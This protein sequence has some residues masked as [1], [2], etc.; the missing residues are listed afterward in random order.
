MQ[1]NHIHKGFCSFCKFLLSL[2]Y[3][4]YCQLPNGGVGITPFFLL[5]F[6]YGPFVTK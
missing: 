4:R 1:K 3:L 5:N 2:L 6:R